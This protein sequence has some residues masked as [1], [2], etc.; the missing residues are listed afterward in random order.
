M[1]LY[2]Y[3]F[4]YETDHLHYIFANVKYRGGINLRWW[5]LWYITLRKR[6]ISVCFDQRHLL[7][8]SSFQF[9]IFHV[10][11]KY[12]EWQKLVL[13]NIVSSSQTPQW[14][15]GFRWFRCW[16]MRKNGLF[17]WLQRI[18]WYPALLGTSVWQLRMWLFLSWF[19]DYP[20]ESIVSCIFF[21]IGGTKDQRS[22]T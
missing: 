8:A 4:K 11:F 21:N 6:S 18:P 19:H 10:F 5:V 1:R 13:C 9:H 17:A 22:F 2:S 12:C 7:D 16:C 14:G 15:F 3:T 20:T